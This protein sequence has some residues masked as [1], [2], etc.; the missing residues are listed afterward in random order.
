MEIWTVGH[1]T[2]ALDDFVALLA[3]HG[4]EFVADVRTV[5]KSRRHPHF[6]SDALARELPE[7]GLGYVHLP[8]LGGFRRPRA[9]SPN[10]GWRNEAFRGY[11]DHAMTAEFAEGL[12]ELRDLGARRRTAAMCSEALWWRCHR[13]L[14]ADRLV[15]QGDTVRH[16]AA[17][18]RAAEH[19]MTPFAA[20]S[21]DGQVVYPPGG[22]PQLP[23]A[24]RRS[25]RRPSRPDPRPWG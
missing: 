3:A 16:I 20:V 22:Q 1:S 15:A 12:A 14:V 10:A 25:A 19:E 5:P 7:R 9:D 17:D 23:L 8:R 18:G 11:A 24:T 6:R 21:D 4:I 2:H 13:R